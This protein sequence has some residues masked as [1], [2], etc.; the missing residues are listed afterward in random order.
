MMKKIS[1]TLPT[2]LPNSITALSHI[3]S[4]NLR[5]KPHPDKVVENS[6]LSAVTPPDITY[7]M[8]MPANI[9]YEGKLSNSQLEAIVYG[10]Q[11]HMVDLPKPKIV[12]TENEAPEAAK[13]AAAGGGKVKSEQKKKGLQVK[14]DAKP[15]ADSPALS[16]CPP[17]G[18]GTD[19]VATK[20]EPP[21]YRA[22]FLLGD[23]AGMGKGR[24][25][26]GFVVENI[27][28]GRNKHVWVSVSSDLYEDAKRDLSDLGMETYAEQNCFN[29][30]KL[31]YG[32]LSST[33][34][35]GKGK[36]KKAKG[37]KGKKR[38][39][40]EINGDPYAE[41]VMFSTYSTLVA[42]KTASNTR[43]EQ[44]IQWCG[45]DKPEEFD[46]LIMFDECH[47]A[48]TVELD[49]QGNPTKKS[50]QTAKAVVELQNRLPR[51]RVVYC[52]ATSVSEPKNLGFMSR[53]GLW[54]YGTEH[55]M[56]FS[57][58]LKGIKRL[59]TGAMELH[60]MHL[61]SA[62]AI[63]ART[64]SYEACEFELIEDVSDDSVRKIYNDA[65]NLWIDLQSHLADRCA[66][67]EKEGD[68]QKK[69]NATLEKQGG[70]GLLSEEQ[71]F[72]QGLN[73]DSDSE[74]EEEDEDDPLVIQRNLRRKF[75][76]RK[77]SRLKGLFWSS[78]QRFFR[79]LCIA[80]KSTGESRA[81]GAAKIAGLADEGGSFGEAF[82]SAPNEDLK[83]TI[84][85][86]FPLPPKPA[87]VIAPEFLNHLKKEDI[88]GD[89]ATVDTDTASVSDNSLDSSLD[90]SRPSRRARKA[91]SYDER[92]VS[93]EGVILNL[94][95]KAGTGKKSGKKRNSSSADSDDESDF[96]V[97]IE[98]DV[99]SDSDSDDDDDAFD[100]KKKKTPSQSIAWNEIP[101]DSD[102]TNMC[103][104]DRIEYKRKANYRRA[105]EKVKG[106]LDTVDNLSL[107]ANPLDRLLN[108]L[109]GPDQVAELTGRKSRQI[110]QYNAMTDKYEVIYE[111]R[112]G[113]G[114]MDQLNIEEK[115]NFQN[116]S[117]LIA[118]LSEAAS[119]GISLQADKR[120]KNQRRRVHITIELPWSADKAI[121][122][123]GRT[124]RSN[125]T[126]GPLYKFLISDVG[127][128]KRFASAVAKRL[129][130]LGALTQGDRRATGSANSLGLST[131]DM[132]NQYGSRAL[133]KMLK[134]IWAC[135]SNEAVDNEVDDGL[136]V[137]A[138]KMIDGHLKEAI[139]GEERGEGTLE[140]N[141]VPFDDDT[142]GEKTFRSMMY[143]LLT[144]PCGQLASN[145]VTAIKEGRSVS[146][147]FESL[148]DGSE[149]KESVKEKIDDEIKSALDAG[150]NFNVRS[151]LG[152]CFP[153]L[154]NIWL[155]DVG[156]SQE[157]LIQG[158]SRSPFGVAKF[159]NRLLGMNLKRQNLVF[160]LFV[161]TL[162]AEIRSAKN[163]GTYDI[164]IKTTKG[165]SVTF[166]TKPQ[167][168][169]F[170]GLTA[171]NETVEL[172]AIQQD[173][174]LSPEKM[175]ELYNEVKDTNSSTDSIAVDGN[176]DSSDEGQGWVGSFRS[177]G[178]RRKTN[179]ETGFYVDNRDYLTVTEKV[180]FIQNLGN[181]S[182]KC[183]VA[184]PN[185]GVYTESKDSLKLKFSR[186]VFRNPVSVERAMEI[187]RR[188]YNLA[189][190]PYSEY[191]Q[192]SCRGRHRESYV[193]AG[194]IVPILNKILIAGKYRGSDN[195]NAKKPFNVV[196]VEVS[197]AA[198]L[199]SDMIQQPSSPEQIQ[200]GDD[201]MLQA[202]PVVGDE[203]DIGKGVARE[204]VNKTS[205][206]RFRGAITKYHDNDKNTHLDPTGSYFVKFSDGRKLEMDAE[207]V[208][209]G[210]RKFE[211]EVNRLVSIGMPR[212]DAS[213]I[214]EHTKGASLAKTKLR[215]PILHD[216]EEDPDEF[217]RNF[218]Q[219]YLDAV[220]DAIVGLEF[221]RDGLHA[222]V[223]Q[224]L[225]KQLLQKGVETTR[226]LYNLERL[227]KA[228]A[229]RKEEE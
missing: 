148:A 203:D 76:N 82:V 165:Q 73:E 2:S 183:L 18:A 88:I 163:S 109:G 181:Q 24:T 168:F 100:L 55:P 188:E 99:L 83:R 211:K 206:V 208:N 162:D 115:N 58:F 164:G 171:P 201:E 9:I 50:T 193:F 11:R 178:R 45:G 63:V 5:S 192:K 174:G 79:T 200:D 101:L 196:R 151:N 8:V 27:A 147:Y 127:G 228:E 133:H 3:F 199:N 137:E 12:T 67:L 130:L 62:G 158:N 185:Y 150:L 191:Y 122:Q 92:N 175:M 77:P 176:A 157:A 204:L 87:G 49:A 111:K 7:N 33:S 210:R 60:A 106:W 110:K 229:Q 227:E 14:H 141:L 215:K 19:S 6:T 144:G 15:Q 114:P 37:K 161:K 159:L 86:M 96:S 194:S 154:C 226:S 13:M 125:Q 182:E 72:Y 129:A 140:E 25:L 53:L 48:K 195:E 124:H 75:R 108:E 128:E 81:K 138:L 21:S 218:E 66:R 135:A 29:L 179:I 56:G 89:D 119:T 26:A 169:S 34:A 221:V 95:T 71:L 116:G 80:S 190:I 17:S 39:N 219:E 35:K 97:S 123:L 216:G 46:G 40:D 91:V 222:E 189:D 156:V 105:A 177:N 23:G 64:L 120:V 102:E 172:Y 152:G 131:F 52:S 59:G 61:K 85:Q 4:T 214:D 104:S 74:G 167:S 173:K 78:H 68:V 30:G 112:K 118:I 213:S 136:Y 132:D 187:W 94:G 10:C 121:Q 143:H 51:A 28:R 184:R 1:P 31:P 207:Q 103:L 16:P 54:G 209:H 20:M 217:E 223:L 212:E 146:A 155:Y 166:I 220:P 153:V 90:S 113:E 225:S 43:L 134:L 69:I 197:N 145:R 22:G 84:M 160:E 44:L 126:T 180:F 65:A 142:E 98:G 117:K 57:Q 198:E 202:D 139:D 107:P 41:G 42:K 170:R 224:N 205:K 93:S 32:S 47:K 149:D 38:K 70:Q 36:G 186:G